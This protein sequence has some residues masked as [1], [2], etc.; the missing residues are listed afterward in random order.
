MQKLLMLLSTLV[1]LV[2]PAFATAPV[3]STT[4]YAT[5]LKDSTGKLVVNGTISIAPVNNSG[6]AISYRA[7]QGGQTTDNAVTTLVTNG[8]FSI[9]LP[10]TTLTEPKNVCFS[11]TVRDN[12]SGKNLLGPGYTCVQPAGSGQAVTGLY[13]WCTAATDTA[14]GTCD[15]DLYD[16][17]IPANIVTSPAGPQGPAGPAGAN[18]AAA[19]I[20]VGTTTTGA[21][22]T[23]ASVVNVGSDSAAVFDF[24]IPQGVP[25]SG[26]GGTS[27]VE[28]NSI[29]VNAPN[30]NNSLPAAPANSNNCTWQKDS[31]GNVS[32]YVPAPVTLTPL[33][34]STVT[35]GGGAVFFGDSTTYAGFDAVGCPSSGSLG[36]E[37]S[38]AFCNSEG[39]LIVQA[40]GGLGTVYPIAIS[41]SG[42]PGTSTPVSAYGASTML[43]IAGMQIYPNIDPGDTANPDYFLSGGGQDA[44]NAGCMILCAGHID[45]APATYQAALTAAIGWLGTPHFAKVRATDAACVQTSGTWSADNSFRSGI[46]LQATGPAEL[47]C[48]T[49]YPVANDVIAAWKVVSGGTATATFAIDKVTT[50]TWNAGAAGSITTTP[51]NTSLWWGNRYTL[52]STAAK[53]TYTVTV[54]SGTFTVAFFASPIPRRTHATLGQ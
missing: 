7:P 23:P 24:T 50:D 6:I 43:D 3:G 17:E 10:D 18:G 19:T 21:P 8:V 49:P 30:F 11:V 48:T 31:S 47:T 29:A 5:Q 15:F 13:A 26:P 44:D 34:D 39:Y 2:L 36:G 35:E 27:S 12:V 42:T 45:N 28:I 52:P 41:S 37:P 46:A 1:C 9:L 25:G 51:G 33:P 53:H 14:G 4:F 38:A 40:Y 16:P 22:G 54:T 20:A 32:C